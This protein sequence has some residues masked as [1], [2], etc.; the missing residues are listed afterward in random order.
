MFDNINIVQRIWYSDMILKEHRVAFDR[1]VSLVEYLA[2]FWNHE[3]VQKVREMREQRKDHAFKSDEEFEE[4]ILNESSQLPASKTNLYT[5]DNLMK[6]EIE[7]HHRPK[8]F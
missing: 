4:S 3:A 1:Q 7:L 8:A 5:S 2:S 6:S